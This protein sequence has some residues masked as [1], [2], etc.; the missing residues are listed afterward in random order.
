MSQ[1]AQQEHKLLCSIF[2][3][4]AGRSIEAICTCLVDPKMVVNDQSPRP[5]SKHVSPTKETDGKGDL[6]GTD[7]GL[8][9]EQARQEMG[10]KPVQRQKSKPIA[11][12]AGRSK[13]PRSSSAELQDLKQA[14]LEVMEEHEERMRQPSAVDMSHQGSQSQATSLDLEL[15][16]IRL[17]AA[18]DKLN[19]VGKGQQQVTNSSFQ[20]G[21][22]LFTPCEQPSY[23]ESVSHI[24]LSGRYLATDCSE[25]VC[26]DSITVKK[27][28]FELCQ[29]WCSPCPS[30]NQSTLML[31][32]NRDISS[33]FHLHYLLRILASWGCLVLPFLYGRRA[34]QEM[35][36]HHEDPNARSSLLGQSEP[37]SAGMLWVHSQS[38][39][40]TG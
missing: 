39:C 9:L 5:R 27:H 22:S 12:E 6:D 17:Q 31:I 28:L 20:A 19:T 33:Q 2:L 36:L 25:P 26:H 1:I 37:F 18:H 8:L 21:D 14:A 38:A 13:L 24:K 35:L 10:F 11:T 40:T 7:L 16:R 3:V 15:N 29:P 30:A 4:A 32:S 34:A 23:L